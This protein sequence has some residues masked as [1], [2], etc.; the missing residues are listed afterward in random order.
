ME[1]LGIEGVE[2]GKRVILAH[3]SMVKGPARIGLEGTTIPSYPDSDHEVF[4]SFGS[5]VDGAILEKI[6]ASPP[7]RG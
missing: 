3:G 7:S 4:L 5:E 2:I 6:P 1:A